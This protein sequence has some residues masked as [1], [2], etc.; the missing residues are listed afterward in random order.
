MPR[1]GR[2]EPHQYE[3]AEARTPL[4][5]EHVSLRWRCRLCVD[6]SC[7]GRW[8][9]GWECLL[10]VRFEYAKSVPR[11]SLRDCGGLQAAPQSVDDDS[12]GQIGNGTGHCGGP[13]GGHKGSNF[14]ELH[15]R[16]RTFPV[17]LGGHGGRKFLCVIPC[18]LA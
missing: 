8:V 13:I 15:Q 9:I 11:F 6:G 12:A 4:K 2:W 16:G 18:P 1:A 3:Q 7:C 17:S 10:S 14:S 5:A